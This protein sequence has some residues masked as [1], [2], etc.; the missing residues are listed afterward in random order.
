M[1]EGEIEEELGEVGDEAGSDAAAEGDMD[2]T[3]AY[4]DAKASGDRARMD[5]LLFGEDSD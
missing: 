3:R 4:E 5:Q 1:E 2:D